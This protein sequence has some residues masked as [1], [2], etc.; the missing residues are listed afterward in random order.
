MNPE[1][2]QYRL[3]A[4]AIPQIVWTA[5]PDGWLDYYNH[6][7]YDYTGLSAEESEG[8]GWQSVLHPD[9]LE[10]CLERWKDAVSSG[11]IYEIEYRFR[12]AADGAYRWHLGR[13]LPVRDGTG[14]IRKWF[15]T[16]TDIDDRKRAEIALG[17]LDR[18]SKVLSSSLDY[19]TTLGSVARMTVPHMA[20]WCGID[21]IDAGGVARH[22]VTAHTDPAMVE[23][24]EELYRRYPVAPDSPGGTPNVM[25]IGRSEF[26]PRISDEMLVAT[27]SNEEHLALLRK[28]G[29][30]SVMIIPLIARNR[31]LGAISLVSSSPTH[32]FD[33]GDLALAE[34]LAHRA[35][36]A[37]DN[38]RLYRQAE[39]QRERLRVTLASIGDAVITTDTSGRITF[40]NLAAESLTGWT[41]DEAA[42]HELMEVFTIIDEESRR[43]IESPVPRVFRDDD[44][45]TL[46]HHTILVNREGAEIPIDDSCAPIRN[47][48]GEIDGMIL[49]FRDD[50]SRRQA[51]QSLRQAKEAAESINHA[52][53]RLLAVLS[54]ELRTPLT[55]ALGAVQMMAA[56][57][58]LPEELR[59]FIDIIQRNIEVETQ[60]IDDLLDLT[61]LQQGTVEIQCESLDLHLLLEQVA[62]FCRHEI[63]GKEMQLQMQLHALRHRVKG[64][65]ARLQ[66]SFRN[67]I[68]NAVKFTPEGGTIVIRTG[69]SGPGTIRVEIE[70]NGIGIDQSSLNRIFDPF[71]QEEQ[72]IYRHYGG[73]GLGLAISRALIELHGGRVSVRSAGKDRGTTF[74]VELA[75]EE[76][77]VPLNQ[78]SPPPDQSSGRVP[79]RILIVDDHADTSM[80]MKLLLER[81]GYTVLTADSVHSALAVAASEGFDLL[82]SDIGLPDG[83]GHELIEQLKAYR[84]VPSIALSGFGMEE[85][86]RRSKEAGFDEHMTKPVSFQQLHEVIER[87]LN[88]K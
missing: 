56:I 26:Y 32:H 69:N 80:V 60:L 62:E 7:W 70:D 59:M 87:L 36:I 72:T 83:S 6:Q 21:I 20:D 3:I 11:E 75:M 44:T 52:K 14:E 73:L 17:F 9:D 57:P 43:T 81:R 13:A 47:A 51:E 19:E 63:E 22:V 39:E 54:H 29:F 58:D 86:I 46:A 35:A 10:P 61:W 5:R 38:A 30:S 55:P 15:G 71:E 74:V 77:E 16:C 68:A 42:G 1:E 79:V 24:A 88:G 48:D 12:R 49:V 41:H 33:A 66:Q 78:Q 18:V 53:D 85:D 45:I 82:V 25:R 27:A 34:E 37:V 28:I 76:A 8:W 23:W 4:E 84:T 65:H 67:I 64:D 40:M 31:T 50:S 2:E